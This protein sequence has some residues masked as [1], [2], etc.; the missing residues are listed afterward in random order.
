MKKLLLVIILI[1]LI[2]NQLT[3]QNQKWLTYDLDS[4]ISI[5]M[6]YEVYKLDTIASGIKMYQLYSHSEHSTFLVQ[7][8]PLEEEKQ[9]DALSKLPY[10]EISLKNYYNDIIKGIE[11]SIPYKLESKKSIE[12]VTF[13]GYQLRFIDSL[14]LP[15][16]EVKLYILNKH[17][18]SFFYTSIEHFEQKDKDTFLNSI[19][20]NTS[21]DVNQY[22]GKPPSYRAGYVFG[23]TFFYILIFGTILYFIFRKKK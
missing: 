15:K 16:Y 11:T 13:K 23:K 8:M 12:N 1:F 18:Y 10:D 22:D 14:N 3:S 19:R 7:K 2:S 6:P 9:N 5:E 4:I 20:I 21:Y 17:L